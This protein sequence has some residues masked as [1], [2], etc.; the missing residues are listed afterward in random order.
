MEAHASRGECTRQG[1]AIFA[2]RESRR[3]PYGHRRYQAEEVAASKP[4]LPRRFVHRG[5][6]ASAIWREARYFVYNRRLML[7]KEPAE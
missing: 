3:C 2:N 7:R 1:L 5:Q 4:G 6:Q